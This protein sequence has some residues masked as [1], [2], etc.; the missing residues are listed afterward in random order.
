MADEAIDFN[1]QI[2]PLLATKCVAC[3]GPDE[4]HREADLRLDKIEAAIEHG[5]IT[6]GKAGK[7]EIIR[8]IESNDSDERM[9]P[10]SSKLTLTPEQKEVTSK[11]GQ[12]GCH[13]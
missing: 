7:S 12:S 2:R 5:A 4:D 6:P 8:R 13:T 3:H 11:L 10:P 1:Q 9:P